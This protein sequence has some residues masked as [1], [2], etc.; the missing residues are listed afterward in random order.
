MTHGTAYVRVAA[1]FGEQIYHI[2]RIRILR[3]KALTC[4]KAKFPRSR[5]KTCKPDM[6]NFGLAFNPLCKL[7]F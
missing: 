5:K 4:A 1:E 7:A 6:V 2:G 3:R